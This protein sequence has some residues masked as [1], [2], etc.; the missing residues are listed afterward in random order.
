MPPWLGIKRIAFIPVDRPSFNEPLGPPP[1]DWHEQIERRIFFELDPIKHVDVSLRNYIYT[2]SRGRADVD[3]QVLPVHTLDRKDVP[4]SFLASTYE[5]SLRNQGFDAAALV[6]IGHPGAG[7]GDLGVGAYWARFVME[8]GV[9]VWAMELTHVLAGFADIYSNSVPHDLGSYDNM[10]CNC[11]THP[12][13]Y[14]KVQL[15]WLDP[16]AIVVDSAPTAEFHLHSLALV[17]PPPPGRVT[18]V[19]IET[20][21][22]PLFVEARQRVDQFDGTNRWNGTGIAGE[23]VI[24]YE[25]VGVQNPTPFAGE[26]DPL[27]S[28]LTPIALTP[29]QSVTSDSGVTV[30]VTAALNGG[31]AATITNPLAATV[32]VPQL[33]ELS[34]ALARTELE[35]LGL[36]AHFLGPNHT[37]SWVRSQSPM[38]GHVVALGTTVSVTLSDN[39]IP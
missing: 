8:E 18:A 15:G 38:A 9:G 16:S 29:G 21:D 6:M 22:H 23:G 14:S 25:L 26:I 17:Q 10:A 34:A 13:A 11:G 24:V 35:A 36:V 3:G 20:G 7:Q 19:Q 32:V 5:Q 2:V 27:I 31:F 37:G 12:S 30:Q 39:P 1:P 4:P 33:H 28:L